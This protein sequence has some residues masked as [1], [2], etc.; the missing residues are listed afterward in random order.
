MNIIN[1]LFKFTRESISIGS[2]LSISGKFRKTWFVR[3]L[4]DVVAVSA[5]PQKQLCS[6]YIRNGS[7]TSS[8]ILTEKECRYLRKKLLSYESDNNQSCNRCSIGCV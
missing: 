4:L 8:R 7:I 1:I 3:F 5:V 6:H 2:L